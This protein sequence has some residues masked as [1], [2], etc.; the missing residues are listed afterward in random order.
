MATSAWTDIGVPLVI[1]FAAGA[2]ALFW[3]WLQSLQRGTTFQHM[4]RRELEEVAPNSKIPETQPWWE[5]LTKRF[6][7]EEIFVRERVSENREFLL[8]LNPTVVYLVSQ[9]W[10][11]YD[12]R[13]AKQWLHFLDELA[14]NRRVTS[15]KL[16]ARSERLERSD[17]PTAHGIHGRD[18][19]STT[20]LDAFAMSKRSQVCSRRG[21]RPTRRYF[22]SPDLQS[23][24]LRR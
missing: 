2:I 4:I 6:I 13:D 10:S 24:A 11:A 16:E 21:V 23:P 3:P 20:A 7:H 14:N 8:S 9:L 15:S 19:R 22:G 1:A 18:V 17:R 12:R 5:H